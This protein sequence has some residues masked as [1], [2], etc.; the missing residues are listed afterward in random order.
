MKKLQILFIAV[1]L[2]LI[3]ASCHR[4]S[5]TI[6]QT[7]D[8]HN[9]TRV[10]YT[11]RIIFSGDSKQIVSMSSNGYLKFTKND[12]KLNVER[13]RTGRIVYEVNGE[14][15]SPVLNE[16]GQRLLTEAIKQITKVKGKR[17]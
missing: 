5:H 1:S 14:K 6:I 7:N 17:S 8:D 11:G 12:E 10:E 3:A 4:G 2:S 16:D 9:I 15:E 13:N